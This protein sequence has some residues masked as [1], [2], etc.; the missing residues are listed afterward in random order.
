MY[1]L[2]SPSR[3]AGV[4]RISILNHFFLQNFVKGF[5]SL[6]PRQTEMVHFVFHLLITAA[7]SLLT[8]T[9]RVILLQ[10]PKLDKNEEKFV[11][12]LEFDNFMFSFC[13]CVLG[14]PSVA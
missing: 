1:V 3:C 7:V 8:C 10:A 2:Q 4:A 9:V 11:T 14:L 6:T 13:V 5:Y 12:E